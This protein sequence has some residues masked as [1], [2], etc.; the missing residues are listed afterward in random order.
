M[1]S[2]FGPA[3]LALGM[4]IASIAQSPTRV[5]AAHD[6]AGQEESPE[7]ERTPTVEP[8]APEP[9]RPSAPTFLPDGFY[10]GFALEGGGASN[11]A[12]D[13]DFEV[14]ADWVQSLDL[15]A[16]FRLGAF[17]FEAGLG[18]QNIQVSSLKL[19]VASPFP[20]DDYAGS[21]A[22]GILMANIYIESPVALF[23]T[24][25]PYVGWGR[26]FSAVH[27]RYTPEDCYFGT[28]SPSGDDIVRDGDLVKS[29]QFMGGL[30]IGSDASDAE[31]YLG[32]RL[33]ETEDL[34]FRT[35]GNVDFVQDGLETLTLLIGARFK[36]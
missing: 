17:R 7:G 13:A 32:Y 23:G 15:D 22:S 3:T 29:R 28:C 4:A 8:P 33:F 18:I 16:G 12:T 5:L 27:A 24:V 35:V 20:V 25:R 31:Y 26:G 2:K 21:L 19:G 6:P 11:F 14:G 1:T 34:E 10:Y 9:I 36:L 30:T